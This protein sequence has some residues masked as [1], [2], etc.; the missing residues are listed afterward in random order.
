MQL[1]QL[2]TSAGQSETPEV[3]VSGSFS[4]LSKLN[5]RRQEMPKYCS[6]FLVNLRNEANFVLKAMLLIVRSWIWPFSEP[7]YG[8]LCRN[9]LPSSSC[10]YDLVEQFH[11]TIWHVTFTSN[12]F[13]IPADASLNK[14]MKHNEKYQQLHA[15]CNAFFS[16]G[17]TTV[18]LEEHLDLNGAGKNRFPAASKRYQFLPRM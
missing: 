5:L 1:T 18:I 15:F 6:L 9:I 12:L 8:K 3:F 4:P 17:T 16:I 13:L 14:E 7:N 2:V 10:F 11:S